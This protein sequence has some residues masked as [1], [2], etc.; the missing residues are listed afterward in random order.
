MRPVKVLEHNG[1]SGHVVVA[2][3]QFK[4]AATAVDVAAARRRGL[5]DA[6]YTLTALEPDETASMLSTRALL[7]QIGSLIARDRLNMPAARRY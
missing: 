6:L 1:T 4:G 2:P 5:L 3:D 7:Q